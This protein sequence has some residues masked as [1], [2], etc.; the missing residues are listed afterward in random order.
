MRIE[1]DLSCISDVSFEIG[2][3]GHILTNI[4]P[5]MSY[6]TSF[7]QQHNEITVGFSSTPHQNLIYVSTNLKYVM[8]SGDQPIQNIRITVSAICKTYDNNGQLTFKRI[9]VP[10]GDHSIFHC[11]LQLVSKH[12]GFNDSHKT[13]YDPRTSREYYQRHPK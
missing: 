1:T 13:E 2:A 7:Q 8:L 11:K 3:K 5:Q 10:L 9:A 4:Q 6:D 12:L